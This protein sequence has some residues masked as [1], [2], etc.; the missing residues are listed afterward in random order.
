MI[1]SYLL[2]FVAIILS[3]VASFIYYIG[4]GLF[5]PHSGIEYSGANYYIWK[6]FLAVSIISFVQ[7]ISVIYMGIKSLIKKDFIKLKKY[8]II[9]SLVSLVL[10]LIVKI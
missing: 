2:F 6:A 9:S 3:L 10:I 5:I 1:S 8:F 7:L 4:Y